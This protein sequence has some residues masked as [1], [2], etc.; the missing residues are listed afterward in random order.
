MPVSG[1][2][3]DS[4]AFLR[5]CVSSLWGRSSLPQSSS[6]L[7]RI[8]VPFFVC[9]D[10]P[11]A[12]PSP[13]PPLPACPDTPKCERVSEDYAASAAALYDAVTQALDAL[14]PVELRVCPERYGAAASYRVGFVFTDEVLVQ[15][16]AKDARSVLHV[17]SASRI[18]YQDLGVNRR[19]IERL[20]HDV[21]ER[22][23]SAPFS[24][25]R[26]TPP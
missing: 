20:L 26:G 6:H 23:S 12:T 14:G 18:G 4:G 5:R 3:P 2:R 19:R 11:P 10:G 16:T 24:S 1:S 25:T 17:R 13:N 9:S 22:V 8:G 7:S 15:V 21:R